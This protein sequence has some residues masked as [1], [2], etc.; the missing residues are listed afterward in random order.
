MADEYVDL[1]G[2]DG[3]PVG[4][5]IRRGEPHPPGTW[6][7]GVSVWL[8]NASGAFL[9]SQ[10][11]PDKKLGGLWET[12]G[13]AIPSGEA[14]RQAGA[15][16]V[17]EE[18]GLYIDPAA[19][20]FVRTTKSQW[21]FCD[22]W[23]Y[24]LDVDI[25]DVTVQATEV[26][27]ARWATKDD[28]RALDA[29]EMWSPKTDYNGDWAAMDDERL[30]LYDMQGSLTPDWVYRGREK[31]PPNRC[32]RTVDVWVRNGSG[33]WL[34]SRRHP[35]KSF[36]G[37]WACTCGAIQYNEDSRTTAAR[38]LFEEL[39]LRVRPAD[40]LHAMEIWRY[41]KSICIDVWAFAADAPVEALTLQPEEV[42]A[43]R[44]ATLADIRAL[45]AAGEWL[46][47]IAYLDWLA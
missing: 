40:G 21:E 15:R 43:A 31:I 8:R 39:G 32:M 29:Q 17:A 18:L 4:I 28:I 34:I 10:R 33:Q 19:M 2:E 47:E 23:L 44:W 9:I 38:E 46:H 41:H 14:S 20:H 5:T 25:L 1:L 45:D 11:H 16:E 35:D 22:I 30:A 27:D 37:L 3:R 26:T 36:G 13:G 42:T 24:E 7:H 12:T 6:G